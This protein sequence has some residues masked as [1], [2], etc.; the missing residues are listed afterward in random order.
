MKHFSVKGINW[1]EYLSQYDLIYKSPSR[2]WADG[3][4]LGNGSLGAL[5]YEAEGFY[6]E[7]T[8]NKNDVWDY[9][10]PKYKRHDMEYIRKIA[11]E[12]MNF[13]KEMQKE[14]I[15]DPQL[16][17]LPS[18]KTCGQL[19]LCFGEEVYYAPGHKITKRLDLYQATLNSL[20]DKH[21]SHPRISSFICAEDNI[22]VIR[23]REVSTMVA[24]RNRVE[25]FRLPDASMPNAE[26]YASEDTIWLEQ[27]I[28]KMKY[29]MM[30]KIVPKGGGNYKELFKQT[31]DKMWWYQ[32]EPSMEIKAVINGQYAIAPVSGDFDVLLTV[33]TSLEAKEPVEAARKKLEDAAKTGSARLHDAHKEWWADFWGKSYV[34]LDDPVLEQLWYIS[35]YNQASALR[36]VP[37]A[38][39]CG[40]WFGQNHSPVQILPWKGCYT[41]DYNMQLPV[42][43]TFRT[44]HP[45]LAEAT[46]QTLLNQLP[47]A[48][49]NAHEL[50]NLLGALYSVTT[51]PSG[52][53][54]SSA[55][56]RFCH[57]GGPYWGVLLWW[58][59]LYTKDLDFL[60]T[61]SYPIM[62]EVA[63]FFSEYMVWHEDEQSYHLENSQNPEL[64]YIK[65][66]DPIDT[67]CLLKYTLSATIE[68]SVIFNE[69]AVL[70]EKCRHIIEHYPP[71]PSHE[72][73][74]LPLK[75]LMPDHINH[76]RTLAGV[77]PTGEFDLETTP[78]WEELCLKEINSPNWDFFMK[79]YA[80]NNGCLEGWSGKVYHRGVPACRLG[81]KETA[82]KYLED[83]IK[84]NLKPNGLI[85]HNIAVLANSA[86]SEQNISKIPEGQ[87][88]H[89]HGNEPVK[90]AEVTNGRVWEET[91][92]D[93]ECKEKMYPVLE[94]PAVYLL[95]VSEMLI[96]SHNGIL[97]LF[98]GLP[99][100][101]DASFLDLRAEGP[102]LVSAER[103]DGEVR[104]IKIKALESV[105]W[106]I[107]NPW[108]DKDYIYSSSNG[109]IKSEKYLE[110]NFSAGDEVILAGEEKNLKYSAGIS[111]NK[112]EAQARKIEF[113]DGM[114]AWLGKPEQSA[115]Y[116]ALEKACQGGK[117]IISGE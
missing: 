83:L 57:G 25:M 21:L 88:Y 42:M 113:D 7:W 70:R 78:E 2:H 20:L 60:K 58:H 32:I 104:F 55:T 73:G 1:K 67:L 43:P 38:G 66:F 115:Y 27:Q 4:P 77:F 31:V 61:V 80:C 117:T 3:L 71:Y 65:Y 48:K 105:S 76:S 35:N 100:S 19:R 106:K 23:V 81:L 24:F 92:E 82:W 53:D 75:G 96:Q 30:A 26:V 101:R 5:A 109:K 69:D 13:A 41:N 84:T 99:D 12:D 17:K 114:L 110:L 15:P 72:N 74:F 62:R 107:L 98:P 8:I 14:N 56:Y 93:L 87:I 79:T 97:R 90:L 16:D 47:E 111:L 28:D 52:K 40:L 36:G 39:L 34:G 46:F 94:G 11:S 68:A 49:R 91:T 59:Y 63:V 10:N 44:N 33:V 54:A 45:E 89:D 95:L 64:M 22:L 37:V 108:K 29:V 85:S 51:G 18:P 102:V 50:Y 6:P 112:S 103:L 86:L 116:S 9:R